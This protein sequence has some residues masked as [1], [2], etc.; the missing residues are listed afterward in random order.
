L[1]KLILP[2]QLYTYAL[3]KSMRGDAFVQLNPTP[4]NQRRLEKLCKQRKYGVEYKDKSPM[5]YVDY[6]FFLEYGF[7]PQTDTEKWLLTAI[8]ERAILKGR[9]FICGSTWAWPEVQEAV[10]TAVGEET[11]RVSLYQD[12]YGADWWVVTNKINTKD[13]LHTGKIPASR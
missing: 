4:Y 8:I 12:L 5:I 9:H 11:N 10:I 7:V 13:T 1:S 3:T 6:S 2:E